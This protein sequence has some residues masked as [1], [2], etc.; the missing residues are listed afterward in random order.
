MR[1]IITESQYN[2]LLEYTNVKNI[3]D[4]NWYGL[5]DKGRAEFRDQFFNLNDKLRIPENFIPLVSQLM[6]S[7]GN[8]RNEVE[9]D[10][11]KGSLSQSTVNKFIQNVS[12]AVST[13]TKD[14]K[15]SNLM[16]SIPSSQ[17]M[18]AKSPI[19]KNLIKS[20]INDSVSLLG[21]SYFIDGMVGAL[22]KYYDGN[23]PIVKKYINVLTQMGNVIS[24][25]ESLK[26]NIQ[27]SVFNIL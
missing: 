16:K 26:N 21:K 25:S 1:Y 22:K 9:S 20:K 13:I 18:I 10:V 3:K 8:I 12:S 6:I 14:Q 17:R 27:N 24:N 15:V 23:S 11:L 2:I 5:K 19:G 4:I 7:F